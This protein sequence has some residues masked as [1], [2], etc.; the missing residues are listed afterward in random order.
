MIR[1][2]EKKDEDFEKKKKDLQEQMLKVNGKKSES[3]A[4]KDKAEDGK[5]E[6]EKKAPAA[7]ES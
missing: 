7:A 6:E 2:A 5:V 4:K 1:K 3:K